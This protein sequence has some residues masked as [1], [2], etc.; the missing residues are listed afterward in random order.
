MNPGEI[1]CLFLGDATVIRATGEFDQT[2]VGLFM[3][4]VAGGEVRSSWVR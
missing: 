2:L 1:H 4:A 3:E